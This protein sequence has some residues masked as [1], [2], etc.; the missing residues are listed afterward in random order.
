MQFVHR[1]YVRLFVNDLTSGVVAAMNNAMAREVDVFL[2]VQLWK[3]LIIRQVI[4]D[5][6]KA[7][8]L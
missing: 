3:T 4:Q 5:I 2:L 8:L 7:I 6:A 1:S